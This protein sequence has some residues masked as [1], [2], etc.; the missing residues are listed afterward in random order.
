MTCLLHQAH[1]QLLTVQ[2]LWA[3]KT[4]VQYIIFHKNCLLEKERL[5]TNSGKLSITHT[6]DILRA[7][8]RKPLCIVGV[9]SSVHCLVLVLLLQE[10]LSC[11]F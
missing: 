3:N 8:V 2:Y 7:I 4:L 9:S 1:R 5:E 11:T 6:Q 10:E